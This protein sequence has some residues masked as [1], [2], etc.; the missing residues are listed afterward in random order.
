MTARTSRIYRVEP[1]DTLGSIADKFELNSW[2]AIALAPENL[3]LL[4]GWTT[5]SVL[6]VGTIIKV[7]PVVRTLL[8]ERIFALQRVRPMLQQHF[9]VSEHLLDTNLMSLDI[10]GG[11]DD[12]RTVA[13]VL[14]KLASQIKKD[15]ELAHRAARPIADV[16]TALTLT[17]LHDQGDLAKFAGGNP[18]YVGL[19]WVLTPELLAVWYGMWASDLW[20]ARWQGASQREA[21]QAAAIY[22]NLARSKVMH[23]ADRRIT[24][25]YR[26][27]WALDG[28]NVDC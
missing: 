1:N 28:E 12:E 25:S 26:A 3:P 16:N 20:S 24:E 19:N 13:N 22:L 9:Q 11:L 8:D 14:R 6:T 15:V 21:K 27:I 23:Q 10:V 2:K 7:P 18:E 4:D 17:H 5:E